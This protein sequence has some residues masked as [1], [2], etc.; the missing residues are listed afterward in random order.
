MIPSWLKSHKRNSKYVGVSPETIRLT[1]PT[2]SKISTAFS[3][4]IFNTKFT[5]S[6]V[7]V[8]LNKLRICQQ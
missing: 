2:T 6:G 5:I 7:G 8:V 4:T 3:K 1:I